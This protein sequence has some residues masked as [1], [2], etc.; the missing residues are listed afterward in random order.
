MGFF[1][2]FF[3]GRKG[4]VRNLG[5]LSDSQG[6]VERNLGSYF[7]T[8]IGQ[9]VDRYPGELS[10]PIS[11][12]ETR[13]LDALSRYLTQGPSGILGEAS[14]ALSRIL[15][16]EPSTD[17]NPAATE[18][19]ISRAITDPARATYQ[20]ET[21]PAIRESFIGPGQLFSSARAETERRAGR[22]VERDISAQGSAIRYADEQARRGLAESAQERALRGASIAPSL[23][24]EMEEL[25]LRQAMAGTAIGGLQRMIEQQSLD[26]EV[27]EFV[28]TSPESNPILDKALQLIG[29]P[30]TNM[31]VIPRQP[32][33]QSQLAAVIPGAGQAYADLEKSRGNQQTIPRSG[34]G[35]VSTDPWNDGSGAQGQG[36]NKNAS[37]DIGK[38]LLQLIMASGGAA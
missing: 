22:D 36:A 27:A 4:D 28:R 30:T 31:Q 32:S 17:I 8:E 23:G 9:G 10:V 37:A 6:P 18:E 25:P 5:T 13:G 35:A 3:K 26:R 24:R 12:F 19:F 20:E 14:G 29:T 1:E 33:I 16:G 38:I 11:E 15:S 34:G 21:L 7:S 2:D